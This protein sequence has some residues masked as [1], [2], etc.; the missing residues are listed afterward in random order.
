MI[1]KII[2]WTLIVIVFFTIII[3]LLIILTIFLIAFD[4]MQYVFYLAFISLSVFLIIKI[5]FNGKDK[6]D[7]RNNRRSI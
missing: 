4:L 7:T 3:P 6:D 2:G 5:F 1:K